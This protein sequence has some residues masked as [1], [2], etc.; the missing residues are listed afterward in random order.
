MASVE[1]HPSERPEA[2]R[3]RWLRAFGD[4]LGPGSSVLTVLDGL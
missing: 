1:G 4:T 3:A 2:S